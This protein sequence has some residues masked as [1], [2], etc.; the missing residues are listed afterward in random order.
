MFSFE[1]LR[2]VQVEI[3]NRCQ[4]SC[5]MCLRNI[6]GGIENPSLLLT[7]WDLSKFKNIFTDDVL[8]QIDSISFC[9]NFGDPIMNNSLIDMCEYAGNKNTNLSIIISTNGSA[10][11]TDWW[12]RL[13]RV[14]PKDHKVIFAIDGLENTHEIYRIGT[15]YDMIIRNAMAFISAG[16]TAQWMFI[17]FKHNEHEVETARAISQELGFSAFITKDSKRFGKNFPVLDKKGSISY[18]IEPPS[19]SSIKPVEFLDLKDYKQWQNDVSCFSFE[20]KELFIDANGFIMPCCL[21]SS[22]LYANYDVELYR[23]Y[24]VID[25]TSI[26][27]IASE[28]QKEIFATIREL[29]GVDALDSNIHSIKDIMS[30]EVWQTLMHTKW[31]DRSSSVCKILCGNGGPF[32]KISEQLNRTL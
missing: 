8:T 6:H 29:G 11:T 1:Q 7:D 25:E 10:R 5:P 3:T 26:I 27:G 9:G 4:A 2:T 21:I 22:F 14:L 12:K 24:R 19:N 16:G 17:R 18:Y 23:K 13:A 20:N 15:S 30:T 32:I 31:A 28:V